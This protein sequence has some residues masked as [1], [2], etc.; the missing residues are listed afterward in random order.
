ML[1]SRRPSLLVITFYLL[2]LRGV[3]QAIPE[4]PPISE[5]YVLRNWDVSDGLPGNN[6]SGISQTPD[7]Y[8]WVATG[9]GGMVRFDGARFTPI[10]VEVGNGAEPGGVHSVFTSRE[11]VLWA[12]LERGGIAKRV[13]GR[14]QIVV[15]PGTQPDQGSFSSSFAEDAAGGIWYAGPSK[16]PKVFHWDGSTLRGFSKPEGVD[17]GIDPCVQSGPGGSIWFSAR[18]GCAILKDGRFER[19]DWGSC[20]ALGPDGRMWAFRSNQLVRHREDGTPE[21]Q[22]ELPGLGAGAGV[23]LLYSDREGNLWIG[24]RAKGLFRYRD[25]KC[26]KVPTSHSAIR[27]LYEDREGNLWVG[28]E[29]GGL[30]RVRLS[31]FSL[32]GTNRGVNHESVVSLCEDPAGRMWLLGR[33]GSPVRA[34]DDS[35]QYFAN[36]SG[37]STG[38]AMTIAPRSRGGIWLGTIGALLSWRE[39]EFRFQIELAPENITALREAPGGDLWISTINNGLVLRRSSSGD[40]ERIPTSGGLLQPRALALDGKGRVWVGTEQG[41]VFVREKESFQEVP[42]PEVMPGDRIQFIV[43]DEDDTVWIGSH[44]AGLYRW[45]RGQITHLSTNSGMPTR[46]LRVL[47]IDAEGD[48]W[49]GASGGLFRVPRKELSAVLDGGRSSLRTLVY[50]RNEGLPVVDFSFGFRSATVRSRNGH[51]WFATYSGALEVDPSKLERSVSA[52]PLLIEELQYGRNQVALNGPIALPPH[53]GSLRIAYSLPQLT[54]PEQIRFRYRLE[55]EGEKG[56]WIEAGTQRTAAFPRLAAGDYRFELAAT[57]PNGQWLPK[58]ASLNFSIRAAWWETWGFRWGTAAVAAAGLT[59]FVRYVVKRRM[60]GRLRKLE[61]EH[62]LERERSR[63]ARDIH[64]EIGA[65]LTQLSLA[66]ELLEMDASEAFAQHTRAISLIVRKT[67]EALDQI[68][69]AVNPRHDTVAS[70]LR[71]LGRFA[72]DFLSRAGIRGEI[73]IPH[74]LP[75]EALPAQVRNHLFAAVKEALNNAV[76]HSGASEIRLLAELSNEA[77]SITVSDNGAGFDAGQLLG[78]D[79]SERINGNGLRNMQNRMAEI[80]GTCRIESQKGVG[81]R[82]RFEIALTARPGRGC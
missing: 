62:A 74:E 49:F 63:I 21:V 6:I 45:R 4:E 69:W 33:D 2:C 16:E 36:P 26:V 61:Q 54:A 25:G 41:K 60:Q 17:L 19:M 38:A 11:G 66:S 76:K 77:L 59:I 31:A 80:R 56:E 9:D 47:N 40:Y 58:T 7:G 39:E 5:E 55:S 42:L 65:N 82:V 24:T 15:P 27:A 48:F 46:D 8:L 72:R 75:E 78:L 44:W 73:Q 68:V 52:V 57:D 43:G 29:G 20:I 53:Q 51:L 23:S 1:S 67:V 30:S 32:L 81:S 64:D 12:G 71:Y 13:G 22:A 34:I 79:E 28:T 10:P 37:W 50:G 18:A 35:N 14:M 70:L 3:A